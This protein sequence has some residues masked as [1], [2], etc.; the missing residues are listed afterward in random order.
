VIAQIDHCVNAQ[1][2]GSVLHRVIRQGPNPIKRLI[3]L[4]QTR[5][6]RHRF[7]ICTTSEG[8][9]YYVIAH[10]IEHLAANAWHF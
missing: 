9:D 5:L 2:I 1:F 3:N 7:A 10:S 8:R 4:I 6:Y